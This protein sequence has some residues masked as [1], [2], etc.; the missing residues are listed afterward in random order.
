MNSV[1][2]RFL[3]QK[4]AF[5][6]CLLKWRVFLLDKHRLLAC[7]AEDKLLKKPKDKL[8]F[9]LLI[10]SD[11]FAIKHEALLNAK[12]NSEKGSCL[13]AYRLC[14]IF[15]CLSLRASVE[16]PMP[17]GVLSIDFC[18]ASAEQQPA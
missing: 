10:F 12:G 18:C 14:A 2:R 16:P 5:I 15:Q 3:K 13:M 11:K 17:S 4:Q 1:L 6:Q 9:S 8:S 7:Y